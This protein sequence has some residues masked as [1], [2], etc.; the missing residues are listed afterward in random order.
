M[1]RPLSYT[2]EARN[3]VITALEARASLREAAALAGV[4][5]PTFCR[6]LATGRRGLDDPEAEGADERLAQLARDVDQA[7]AETDVAL[8]GAMY[9]YAVGVPA[10]PATE[11][12]A[13]RPEIPG[14]WRAADALLKF[15]AD[16]ALRR[17]KLAQIKAETKVAEMRAKGTLREQVD[18]TLTPDDPR[19]KEL[20]RQHLGADRQG[21][22]DGPHRRPD[23]MAS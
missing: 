14:D 12:A 18:V 3:R 21:V 5:W 16:A 7:M 19:W 10:Q 11:T 15:R 1:P 2:A 4:P 6:W 20:Q 8:A 23:P 9:R 22:S 13:A 17:A